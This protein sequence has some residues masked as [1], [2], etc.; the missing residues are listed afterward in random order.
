MVY[1]IESGLISKITR[2]TNLRQYNLFNLRSKNLD[3][4]LLIDEK[5]NAI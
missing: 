4:I 1:I 2:Q 5:I 3:L